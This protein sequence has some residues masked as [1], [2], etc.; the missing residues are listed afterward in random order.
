MPPQRL[1]LFGGTFD[2]PHFG[3]LI[4]AQDAA[5]Q[6]SLDRLLFVVAALPPHKLGEDLAPADLRLRMVEE[7]VARN[8][9]L[10]V[11]DVELTR[12]G[13]SYSVDTL[14]HYRRELPETELIFLM[15]A[16]QLAEFHEWQEPEAVG[17]LATLVAVARGGIDPRDMPPM[18]LPR[19]VRVEFKQIEV[20]RIDISSTEVR[21][22]VRSGRSIQYM[23]PRE[24][25]TII[26][27]NRLY[28]DGS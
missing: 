13:P 16:D 20:T 9:L 15:G 22:K 21:E 14:R 10:G 5:E 7:A 27:R 26:E 24:V 18:A 4:V 17:Q 25:R 1:G 6:L 3:H 28:Q 8:P 12:E 23:V 11:S 2:P 19:G